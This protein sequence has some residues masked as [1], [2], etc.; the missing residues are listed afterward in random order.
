M[1]KTLLILTLLMVA[2]NISAQKHYK[3]RGNTQKGKYYLYCHMNG[4]VAW[5]AYAVSKD[6]FHFQ[7]ILNGDSIFS[8]HEVARIEG[9][10]RD[11]Y[12]CRRHN[13]KGYLMV[14][15]DMDA[16]NRSRDRMGKKE[17][18]DNYGIDL[19]T[20]DDLIHW[21]STTFDYRKGRQIF[22]NPDAPSA[23]NDWSTINR[24]WAPQIVWDDTFVWPDGKKGGYLIYY[25]MWNRAEEKYDRMYYSHANDDFT[26]LTQPQ[27]LFDW[28]YATIDADI[29]WVAADQQ[30]HMMIKK[31]G[32]K[33]GLFTA[34]S[35]NLTGP[36]SEPVEDDYVN[37][38]GNKKC[39][40]VSA[41]QLAGDNTWRIAYIEYSSN[42]KNYRICEAD[43]LMRNF[44]NPRNIQGVARP[45]HG[46]FMRITKKEYKKLLKLSEK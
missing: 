38:E 43:E 26:Q 31:E 44:K 17:T 4:G 15:T 40:G 3:T 16:S 36:W 46:S 28:G 32:G 22:M 25:S 20:S 34:T 30:W 19:L 9:R 45:Q 7:D 14:T 18:W 13:G 2:V 29:N 23:Y 5:T 42:P 35:P 1:R 12:I 24:V 37:F 21:K 10:T 41:F 39:E 6:G 27:L 11:A 33:P 8:D